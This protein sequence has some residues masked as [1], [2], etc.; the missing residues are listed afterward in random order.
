M[1]IVEFQ[2]SAPAFLKAQKNALLQRLMCPPAPFAVA[3]ADGTTLVTVVIDRIELGASALVHERETTFDVKGTGFGSE[4]GDIVLKGQVNGFRVQLAQDVTVHVTTLE[5]I[6]SRPDQAPATLVP[7]ACR[8]LLA[9]DVEANGRIDMTIDFSER[10]STITVPPGAS[11]IPIPWDDVE[12]TI[13]TALGQLLPRTTMPID[14]GQGIAS[15]FINAGVSIDTTLSRIAIRGDT[16]LDIPP[17]ASS[18]G[19]CSTRGTS[20]IGS[21]AMTGPCSSTGSSSAASSTRG[22]TEV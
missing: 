2:M 14:V 20:S 6:L 4:S 11:A 21:A 8:L 16:A 12:S 7:V 3:G 22:S 1:A 5:D 17:P 9:I 19:S 18:G 10:D 13:M 15:R